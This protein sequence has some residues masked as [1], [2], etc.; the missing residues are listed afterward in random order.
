MTGASSAR[1]IS[2]ARCSI[3]PMP[4]AGRSGS[5]SRPY[6]PHPEHPAVILHDLRI[7]VAPATGSPAAIPMRAACPHHPRR[8]ERHPPDE[9][10]AACPRIAAGR[11]CDESTARALGARLFNR[12]RPQPGP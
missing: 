6:S 9:A 4:M 12:S 5:A 11:R 3:S 7:E 10:R 8:P 1:P 2:R